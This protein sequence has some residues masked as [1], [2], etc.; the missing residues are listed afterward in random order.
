MTMY[1]RERENIS[2]LVNRFKTLTNLVWAVAE[3]HT[4]ELT[5][6]RVSDIAPHI[7]SRDPTPLQAR[8][9]SPCER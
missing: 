9:D 7:R 4:E 6:A 2:A 8:L 3:G 5:T 1:R